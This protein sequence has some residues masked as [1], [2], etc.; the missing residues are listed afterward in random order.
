MDNWKKCVWVSLPCCTCNKKVYSRVQLDILYKSKYINEIQIWR[1]LFRPNQIVIDQ[2]LY[3]A[4]RKIP[5]RPVT[6]VYENENSNKTTEIEFN[7]KSKHTSI[8]QKYLVLLLHGIYLY[9]FATELYSLW[10]MFFLIW[11]YFSSHILRITDDIRRRYYIFKY[12]L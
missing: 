9:A 8:N 7:S 10:K 1:V 12:L 2:H 3:K 5:S 6:K 4:G 11:K